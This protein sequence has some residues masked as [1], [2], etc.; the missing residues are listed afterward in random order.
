VNPIERL[1]RPFP[2]PRGRSSKCPRPSAP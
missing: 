2:L 1:W